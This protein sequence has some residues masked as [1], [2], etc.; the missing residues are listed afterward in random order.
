M[1]W[2]RFIDHAKGCVFWRTY[3]E[4]ELPSGNFTLQSEQNIFDCTPES[5]KLV[6]NKPGDI[7]K[8]AMFDIDKLQR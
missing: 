5:V 1:F 3:L 6:I 7:E 2:E 8:L 4:L